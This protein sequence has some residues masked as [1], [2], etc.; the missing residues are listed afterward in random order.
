MNIQS[1]VVTGVHFIKGG[2]VI[3]ELELKLISEYQAG[4]SLASVTVLNDEVKR[5]D[6]TDTAWGTHTLLWP[7][8]AV[9]RPGTLT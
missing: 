9:H 5:G 6:H 8:Q 4:L 2:A 7:L 1:V 3:L